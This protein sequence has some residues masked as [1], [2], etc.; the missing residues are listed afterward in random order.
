V[1]N[2]DLDSGELYRMPGYPPNLINPP[3]GCR[4]HPRC[5]H[6]MPICSQREPALLPVPPDPGATPPYPQLAHCWLYQ[7]HD[8]DTGQ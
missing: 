5:P 2:I 1:P 6:V 4:F 3:T 7:E 8:K